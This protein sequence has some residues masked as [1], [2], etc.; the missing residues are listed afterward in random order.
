MARG[1]NA[2]AHET[3]TDRGIPTITLVRRI[4]EG[5][6]WRQQVCL[7]SVSAPRIDLPPAI[8][9]LCGTL[10]VL[11]RTVA[12]AAQKVNRRVGVAVSEPGAVATGQMFK[13]EFNGMLNTSS[14]IDASVASR[15]RYRF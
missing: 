14:S 3:W 12:L 9:S 7:T 4:L 8:G 5:Q 15:Y 2:A 10:Q 6:H 13:F 11:L 1:K